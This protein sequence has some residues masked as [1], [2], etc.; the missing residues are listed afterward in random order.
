MN[1]PDF[2][3]IVSKTPKKVLKRYSATI[4]EKNDEF[5]DVGSYWGMVAF[6]INNIPLDDKEYCVSF[7]YAEEDVYIEKRYFVRRTKYK[8]RLTLVS[9][10]KSDKVTGRLIG[11][12]SKYQRGIRGIKRSKQCHYFPITNAILPAWQYTI[13]KSALKV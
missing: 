2:E 9:L 8:I 4:R 10:W 12:W 13:T 11:H 6:L 5:T 1:L 7:R 3:T